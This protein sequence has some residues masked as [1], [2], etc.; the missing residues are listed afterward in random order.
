MILRSLLELVLRW[1]GPR[2]CDAEVSLENI[3]GMDCGSIQ[4]ENPRSRRPDQVQITTLNSA[5]PLFPRNISTCIL[6]PSNL[7]HSIPIGRPVE[8]RFSA[9]RF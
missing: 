7:D 5:D 4:L 8:Q 3:V 9:I 2:Q 6:F 1:A